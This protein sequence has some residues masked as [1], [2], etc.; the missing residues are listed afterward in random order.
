LVF[1][2]SFLLLARVAAVLNPIGSEQGAF[3]L[4]LYVGAIALAVVLIVAV[5]RAL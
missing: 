5:V 3:R 2:L 1:G 4:L